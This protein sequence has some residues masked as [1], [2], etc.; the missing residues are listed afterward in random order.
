MLLRNLFASKPVRKFGTN[1]GGWLIPK[2]IQLDSNS[3]VYSAG[4]GED[5]SFDLHLQSY[6]NCNILLIDPTPRSLVHL[7][8]L[9]RYYASGD[10]L[11]SGN[12]QKDYEKKI[13]KMNIDFS[14]ISLEEKGLW[15]SI[16]KLKFYKQNNIN[17][18]SQTLVNGMF[19]NDYDLIETCTIKSLMTEKKHEQID[20]LKLDIEGA[21]IRVLNNMLDNQIQPTYLCVEFDLKLKGKD[22]EDETKKIIH[23]LK[24]KG[25][26]ELINDN[27]NITFCLEKNKC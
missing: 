8:E 6:F 19:G 18:V 9:I 16:G 3:I 24:Q 15:D 21:E 12:I 2:D 26:K 27:L 22:F 23:R 25:Y 20:L 7:Q 1:Y 17:N 14:K 13:K 11:F 5:I 4:A 10:W